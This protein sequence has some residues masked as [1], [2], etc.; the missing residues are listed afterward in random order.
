MTLNPAAEARPVY[1]FGPFR[2]DVAERRLMREGAEIALT[3]KTFDLLLT[4]VDGAGR[5]Q[6]REALI[7]ALWP[8]TIVEEH[9]LT[10]HLSTLRRALGDT[11]ASPSYVETVRGHGYR[12][13]APVENLAA[14]EAE[15]QPRVAAIETPGRPTTARPARALVIAGVLA[16]VALAFAVAGGR[17]PAPPAAPGTGGAPRAAR[18]RPGQAEGQRVPP[19]PPP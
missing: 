8:D 15:P 18:A 10:W 1:A 12:F 9:S 3:R 2:L 14:L 6:T 13:I 4:L 17:G 11:G 16:A 5:L 7:Q 19:P